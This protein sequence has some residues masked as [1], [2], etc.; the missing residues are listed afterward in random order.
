MV[1]GGA[2]LGQ[3]ARLPQ[4]GVHSGDHLELLRGEQQRQ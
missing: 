1:G 3:H 4:A 2:E